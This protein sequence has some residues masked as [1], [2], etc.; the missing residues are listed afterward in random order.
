MKGY[1]QH[2]PPSG[3]HE[4][5]LLCY[6][7]DRRQFPGNEAEQCRRLLE[8]MVE[9][10]HA[11]VDFIQL[12]EKDLEA[13]ELEELAAAAV[14]RVRE[15]RRAGSPSR[16]LINSRSDV[17]LAVGAD[18][19]HLRSDDLSAGEARRLLARGGMNDAL[20]G[21]SCHRLE[22]VALAESEGADFALFAPVFA[23]PGTPAAGLE[24]LWRVCRRAQARMPVLALGRVTHQNA[25][26]CLE[27]GA[28]GIAV[29][30]IFQ[31]ND[32]ARVVRAVQNAE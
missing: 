22:Q 11:A 23:K 15:A 18:G 17:A 5:A 27:A 8:K 14:E 13:R 19:V 30:R 31:E 20:L 25:A 1:G 26:A 24:E 21:V 7:T 6:I 12:R 3:A 10:A 9:A 32:T 29:I 16:L 28:A 4:R 2:P